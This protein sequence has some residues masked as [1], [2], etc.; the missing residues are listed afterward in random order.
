[1]SHGIALSELPHGDAFWLPVVFIVGAMVGSFLNV[2]VY[3]LPI[4]EANRAK[5]VTS[6]T[7]NLSVPRSRCPACGHQISAL[8]NI[9]ILSW[10]VLMGRCRVCKVPIHWR[11]PL[12]EFLVG[13]AFVVV[14]HFFL[15]SWLSLMA[16]LSICLAI[17]VVGL[18]ES[19]DYL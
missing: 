1:M 4:I 19:R 15:L 17:V 9:P 14:I 18:D 2:V 7:F 3:R 10:I 16:L 11:Y 8:E 6:P 12:I 13:V 5:G